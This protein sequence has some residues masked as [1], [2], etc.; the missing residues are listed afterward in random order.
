MNR[1]KGKLIVFEGADG[2]GTTT[3][4]YRMTNRLVNEYGD[5]NVLFTREPT[6]GS[7]GELLRRCLSKKCT[8]VSGRAIE[9]LF[10][11]DRISHVERVVRPA[12][13]EGM[14]VVCDR[15]YP[16][17]LVYQSV[18]NTLQESIESMFDIYHRM[19]SEDMLLSPDMVLY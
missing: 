16:S 4:S 19:C 10:R 12:L 7:I 6:N 1:H 3:Q 2:S 17:T 13:E 14:F 9:M 18:K 8:D 5:N 15:Y 11:A